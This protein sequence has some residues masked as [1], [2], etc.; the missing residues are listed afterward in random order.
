MNC[1]APDVA[2][3]VA[4]A[5]APRIRSSADVSPLPSITVVPASDAPG[6]PVTAQPL[7]VSEE[8]PKGNPHSLLHSHPQQQ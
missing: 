4:L 3:T 2:A 8:V 6:F 5:S 1:G 7:T